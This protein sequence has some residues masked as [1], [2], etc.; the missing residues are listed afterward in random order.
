M[1]E[2][3]DGVARPQGFEIGMTGGRSGYV[4][5]DPLAWRDEVRETALAFG[6]ELSRNRALLVSVAVRSLA[7]PGLCTPRAVL[8]AWLL[9]RQ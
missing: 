7:V 2:V 8:C 3:M 1:A 9:A 4:A 6:V 5:L